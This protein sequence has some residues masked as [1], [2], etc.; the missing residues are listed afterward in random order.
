MSSNTFVLNLLVFLKLYTP[1]KDQNVLQRYLDCSVT[2][3]WS[4]KVKGECQW[5]EN[6]EN[7]EIVFVCNSAPNDQI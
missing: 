7:A 1:S 3:F 6:R 5:R 4:R 2:F